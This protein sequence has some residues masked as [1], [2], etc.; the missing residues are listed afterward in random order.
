MVNQP[1][2]VITLTTDF[3]LDDAYVG[4]MKGVMLNINPA[5]KLVDLTHN[6]P[7]QNIS[8]GAFHLQTACPY[9]PTGTV[10]LV[11]IDPGVGSQRRAIAFE[12]GQG[13]YVGP[14][15]GVFSPLLDPSQVGRVIEL[16][17]AQYWRVNSP[18]RTFHGRDIFAPVAAHLASGV[19][20]T[21]LG[22][23]VPLSHLIQHDPPPYRQQAQGIQGVIQAIDHFG[24]L[25][26]NIPGSLV[27]D[28]TGWWI[29]AGAHQFPG[30][31]AYSSVRPGQRVSVI[32]SHG[33]LELAISQGDA[34]QTCQLALNQVVELKWTAE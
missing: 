26:T 19:P 13:Y 34:Q 11:V 21:D 31:W 30:H 23:E 29:Q 8:L 28:R 27:T 16:N 2:G 5:L 12:A 15:N 20:L 4:T 3:G 25:I 32:G 6:V 7:S 14:D 18:S 17:H 1:C 9:F 10:H 22:T 33:W 24:N